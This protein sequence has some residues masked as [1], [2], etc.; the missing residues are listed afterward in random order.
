[1]SDGVEEGVYIWE[2]IPEDEEDIG[3]LYVPTVELSAE[4]KKLARLLAEADAI[5]MPAMVEAFESLEAY[6]EDEGFEPQPTLEEYRFWGQKV[7]ARTDKAHRLWGEFLSE[8]GRRFAE[9]DAEDI[10]LQAAA[11]ESLEE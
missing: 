2:E 10:E 11:C 6:L 9:A 8:E 1:M 4:E 3:E 5:S 7:K